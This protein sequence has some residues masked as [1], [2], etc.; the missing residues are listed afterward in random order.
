MLKTEEIVE[1]KKG[2]SLV[3]SPNTDIE[4]PII[5]LNSG[6]TQEIEPV[7][8]DIVYRRDAFVPKDNWRE[9]N[10]TEYNNIFTNNA[11]EFNFWDS[12][13]SIGIIQFPND[14]LAPLEAI[15]E[16]VRNSPAATSEDCKFVD[17]HPEQ[18]NAIEKVNKYIVDH[19]CMSTSRLQVIGL[20]TTIPGL[21]T[22][23]SSY[24]QDVMTKLYDGMHL[25]S[26][27]RDPLKR[28]HKARNR[29]CINFG[30][31]DRYF[32]FI[33]LTLM[34]MFYALNLSEP[35]DI[36]KHYRGTSIGNEFMKKFPHYPV[37][38]LRVRPKEAYIAP[39]ENI[40]HDAT[41][42]GK[43]YSDIFSCQNYN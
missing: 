19:Y 8:D 15:L 30:C 13:S 22:V 42:I 9:V 17:I 39:T 16:G 29:M 36:Y 43:K 31:E 26:W 21:I 7:F 32:L 37:V 10:L 6:T 3:C 20:Q 40:I 1:L 4:N 33:N 23:A 14:V 25:D 34:D 5:W 41:T 11:S 27:D 35:E 28:R 38:K 2:I 24:N 12:G 18:K